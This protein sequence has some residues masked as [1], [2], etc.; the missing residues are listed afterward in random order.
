MEKEV[1]ASLVN[2]IFGNKLITDDEN[3]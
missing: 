1:G 2:C 3:Y